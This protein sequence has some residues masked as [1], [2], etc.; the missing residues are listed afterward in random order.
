MSDD[1][2]TEIL[3]DEPESFA[4]VIRSPLDDRVW[5]A[6]IPGDDQ[7]SGTMHASTSLRRCKRYA[8]GKVDQHLGD[9]LGPVG[10]FRTSADSW[11]LYERDNMP[12]LPT[13]SE[14]GDGR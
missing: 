7:W 14:G 4:S 10:W 1:Q 13:A 11:D 6:V 5:C 2:Q 12:A 9:D 8:E 3:P